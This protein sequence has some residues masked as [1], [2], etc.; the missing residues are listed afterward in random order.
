MT[1]LS[2]ENKTNLL[3]KSLPQ[4]PHPITLHLQ[5]S[6]TQK[7]RRVLY[8]TPALPGTA[9]IPSSLLRGWRAGLNLLGIGL[10]A[11]ATFWGALTDHI[12]LKCTSYITSLLARSM[13]RPETSHK[14]CWLQAW[15]GAK[16][17]FHLQ[18]LI[19]SPPKCYDYKHEPTV[20]RLGIE[21]RASCILDKHST[22][23]VISPAKIQH[24]F[25]HIFTIHLW[26]FHSILY[27]L[28]LFPHEQFYPGLWG[29]LQLTLFIPLLVNSTILNFTGYIWL[30]DISSGSAL[31]SYAS[32]PIW[33]F[34]WHLAHWNTWVVEDRFYHL[35]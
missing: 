5:F 28:H 35:L 17:D 19:P 15:H 27:M 23:W 9:I 13:Y 11:T 32:L 24:I 26:K 14:P 8:Q 31:Y 34:L 6:T 33:S 3:S 16:D 18:N 10:Q 2:P 12:P 4:I 7:A 29:C 1:G 21:P 25:I 30:H 22:N 20:P